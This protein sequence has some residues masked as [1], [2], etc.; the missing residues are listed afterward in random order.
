MEIRVVRYVRGRRAC[1]QMSYVGRS[2]F[3]FSFFLLPSLFFLSRELLF[4]FGTCGGMRGKLQ[5]YLAK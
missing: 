1:A 2:F 5:L 4:F 3:F